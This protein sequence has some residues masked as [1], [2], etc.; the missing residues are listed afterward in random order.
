MKKSIIYTSLTFVLLAF[1][2]NTGYSQKISYPDS[3]GK[4]GFTLESNDNTSVIINYSI[5]EFSI[6]DITIGDEILKEIHVPGIFLPNDEGAPDL[7]GTGRYIAI[8]QGASVS[9]NVIAS[10]TEVFKNFDIAPAPRIPLD[11][12]TG[13]LEYNKDNKIYSKN[14]LYPSQPVIVSDNSKIRGV[15]V[16][17][18]GVTPFQ[19]N[20]V[21]K[22][23]IIY[24]DLK[25]EI[26]FT[27]GNGHFGDDRLRSRWWDPIIK[28]AVLNPGSLPEIDYS[29][30]GAPTETPDFEYLII[31][32]D[33]PVFLSW[34]DS[35][36]TFRT[37]QG[38]KTGIVTTTDVGGNTTT[39]IEGYIDNAYNTWAVPPAAVLLLGDYGTSG[40]T[41]ISPIYNSY[42]VSDNIYAD[43]DGDQ[44]PDVVLARM[45]AQNATHLET[46]ITKFLDYERNP[47]TSAYFYDHPITALGW[48]TERWF[49]ICSET[50]GGF[51]KNEL[52]KNPV[53]INAVYGGDPTSDPWSTATNTSTVV[54]Y[55]GPS[56]LGYIPATPAEL[57]GF[58]G[59]TATDV[60]NAINSGAFVLQHRDHGGETGWGEPAFQS[61]NINSLTNSDLPWIFSINCLTGKYNISGECFAEKFHRYTYGGHNSGA[62]GITAASEVSYSFVNDTYVWGLY[63]NLWP[64]FMPAETTDPPSRG[65]LPAFG[66]AAGKIFLEQSSWPYN[67]SNKEVTYN[68]FHHHG[69]AFTVL[70]SEVPQYLT[71]NHASALLS[72]VSS[73]T[74]TADAGSFIALTVNGVIIGTADGTGSPVAITIPPQNPGDIMVVT[75]TKQNYYRYSGN[76]DVIPP[77]GPYVSYNNHSIND[78]SGNNNGEADF[79]ENILL[80]V[81]LENMGSATANNVNATLICTD[82]YITIT[83]NSQVY[84]S[85]NAGSQSTINNAFAFTIAND[86][87]DQYILDF[88]LQVTGNADDSWTSY[89]S[90]TVNAPV[91]EIGDLTI[92]DSEMGNGDGKLDPGETVDIIIG[93][94]NDGHSNSPSAIGNLSSTSPYITVTTS[95]SPLGVINVGAT[96]YST[97]TIFIDGATPIGQTVDLIFD[98]VAGLYSGN[99][100]FYESVGLIVEDWETG[101]FSKFPW[102]FSGNANFSVVTESPYEGAFCAKSGDISD[103]QTTSLFI[104]AYISGSGTI[105][106]YRKVSSESNYD[107]LR[108]YIDGSLLDSWSGTV[109]WGEVSYSVTAGEHT[110]E[111]MYYKDSSVSS[112]SDCGWVDY[113]IFPPMAPP[114]APA[115][116]VVTPASFSVTLAQDDMTD[117]LMHISNL[118]EDD[119]TYTTAVTYLNESGWYNPDF[120]L[121]TI[122]KNNQISEKEEVSPYTQIGNTPSE[123]VG[124]VLMQ[125]DIQTSTGDD[126]LLGCE[127][128]GTYLWYS[129][130]GGTAGVNPNQLYK[131]DVNGNLIN[132]YSQGTTSDWGIRDMAFNGTYLYGGDDNGFYQI[133]QTTGVV[134]TMFTGNLGLTTIRALAYNPVNG[135]FYAANWSTG[136]VEFDASGTQYATLTAPGL[137][138][139]YGMAYDDL[140]GNLWIFDRSG[141]P[142]TSFYE[143]DISTQ[144]LTGVSVQVPLLTG[145]TDQMNGGAFYSTNLVPGKIVLGG[146]VQGTPNDTFFALELGDLYTHT[147]LSVTN[148][149]SGTVTGSGTVD[150]TVHFDADGL[151]VGVYL[152]EIA[153]NSNDPDNPQIIVPCTLEVVS[154]V[155]V[156]LIINLEGCYSGLG[157]S[158][159]LNSSGYLPFSQPYNV[160]PWNYAGTESV[161][162][163]P[164]STIVDWVL[165]E[166]RETTGGVSTA[167]P[168]TIIE[169]KAGFVLNNG[170][171]V[172]LDGATSLRFNST[173]T[174]NLFVV[175][176]H[177]NHL[178][179]MTANPVVL[180]AGEYTYDFTTGEG[181]VYGGSN[182]HKEIAPGIWGMMAGDADNDYEI[183]NKDKNDFWKVQL[184]NSGYLSGDFNMNGQVE[185]IDNTLFWEIN[186]GN[187]SYIIK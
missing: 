90:I 64:D 56:G 153:I 175:V 170:N 22:E 139:V 98:V 65:I 104:T 187:C 176:Y 107:Y 180:S 48:Q 93:T 20:P 124:D 186:A 15:E 132:T 11:T 172:G 49:Q 55:F 112:G 18:L 32:P 125:L 85:I 45:T 178:G 33:D 89:F 137:T 140:T 51:W 47:P 128:D 136:I 106:F 108:F 131:L 61:S 31:S 184:G 52:G 100:T 9:Y 181:Q 92:D 7:P 160:G 78:A 120:K 3:W 157:M 62:L 143:Y 155:A 38:I 60:V 58:S 113:I 34:A 8:P 182:G 115:E 43:V 21:T 4:T 36:K 158:V 173:I 26:E 74:V 134:T 27:G 110:F 165:V 76:V 133:D 185:L 35:I 83:D 86:I 149:G 28:D 6:D 117:E 57:G 13:P 118:G 94:T 177:R 130:A 138:S 99:N 84:G 103:S 145:L 81:T 135:H 30:K 91:L 96:S 111:W 88:E 40:S 121:G 127:F 39:A 82:S 53:R 29:K 161:T 116:I 119:L 87:P 73:F 67:T 147:W 17:M 23:L 68:L 5:D 171:I 66:N 63:D 69:D 168:A 150:V 71:V 162:S 148:N 142:T 154:G 37:L 144:A 50:V 129:G 159:S 12:E 25:I 44:L 1:V 167:T 152:G 163:I 122:Q 79:G 109:A 97:F 75:I 59:G 126:Q 146:A 123:A 24:R 102:E 2:I 101:D 54:N 164:N 19:Y 169:R 151:D 183:D 114:P 70:Y 16:I 95:T 174:N 105:S 141:S 46:M 179:I 166:L 14:K 10:R 80:D 42:C 77:S 72:G 156:N 41:V